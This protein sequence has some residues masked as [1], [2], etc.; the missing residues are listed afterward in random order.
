VHAGIRVEAVTVSAVLGSFER[1]SVFAPVRG[2]YEPGVFDVLAP[3]PRETELAGVVRALAAGRQPVHP[4]LGG[5][6]W[7]RR[8]VAPT[9]GRASA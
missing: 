9:S 5:P 4:A 1:D 7:W 6:G 2:H 8:C 3:E